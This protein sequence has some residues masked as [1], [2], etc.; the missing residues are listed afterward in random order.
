[1]KIIGSDW[2]NHFESQETSCFVNEKE[3]NFIKEDSI[4]KSFQIN[5]ENNNVEEKYELHL[6]YFG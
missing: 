3:E 5:I 2:N 1:M 4:F 6:Q